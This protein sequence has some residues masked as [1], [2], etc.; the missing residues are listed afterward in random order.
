MPFALLRVAKKS[1]ELLV[2]FDPPALAFTKDAITQ[3]EVFS[4]VLTKTYNLPDGDFEVE[5]T[6]TGEESEQPT[7]M[8]TLNSLTN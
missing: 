7:W 6:I 1:I 4:P 8:L 5:L 3:D 2:A